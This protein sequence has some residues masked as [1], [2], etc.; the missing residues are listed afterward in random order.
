MAVQDF[1]ISDDGLGY[2]SIGQTIASDHVNDLRRYT[3]HLSQLSTKLFHVS[4][5][6]SVQDAL[7]AANAAGGGTVLVDGEYTISTTLNMEGFKGVYLQGT[8]KGMINTISTSGSFL[9]FVM[10]SDSQPCVS[11]IGAQDCGMTNI[12]IQGE[13]NGAN[14][15]S[16]GILLGRYSG[17]VGG[18]LHSF[19]N[20]NI[21][22]KFRDFNLAILGSEVNTFHN[23][24][25]WNWEDGGHN[26]LVARYNVYDLTSPHSTV[27]EDHVTC[28]DIMF[29]KCST[30]VYGKT[31]TE[32][33]FIVTPSVHNLH[34][35][36]HE[37][38]N[39][40]GDPSILSTGGKA[41]MAFEYVDATYHANSSALR[42]RGVYIHDC[43]LE[44][45]GAKNA[46]LFNHHVSGFR[47]ANVRMASMESAIAMYR[48][49]ADAAAKTV[50]TCMDFHIDGC[51][52]VANQG[53]HTWSYGGEKPV[54]LSYNAHVVDS[55]FNL[56]RRD[57]GNFP[58]SG[59]TK[60]IWAGYS[61]A[62]NWQLNEIITDDAT[63]LDLTCAGTP[64]NKIA[65]RRDQDGLVRREYL[66]EGVATRPATVLN[67]K[68]RDGSALSGYSA[69]DG[70]IIIHK[71]PTGGAIYLAYYDNGTWQQIQLSGTGLPTT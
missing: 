49:D 58:A 36:G 44:T 3:E 60:D 10:S 46:F 34:I 69:T 48:S 9:K 64:I 67:W 50:V 22:G 1:P 41:F 28:T 15:P 35:W 19:Y 25:M 53:T 42:T 11:L 6:Y 39:K 57:N 55:Y 65:A 62:C 47:M 31:G 52:L 29:Q 61:E 21:T 26:V 56:L 20:V 38:S 18:P 8:G 17:G 71:N 12:G 45:E 59:T 30:G 63:R 16:V 24:R 13:V 23:V 27:V 32:C 70:D 66:G 40:P 33:N 51:D 14:I 37:A 5:Y 7:D 2:V 68:A 54:I 4:E 43:L